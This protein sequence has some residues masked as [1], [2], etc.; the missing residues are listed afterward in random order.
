[1]KTKW[2]LRLILSGACLTDSKLVSFNTKTYGE[3]VSMWAGYV[4][5]AW[6][7]LVF[8]LGPSLDFFPFSWVAVDSTILCSQRWILVDLNAPT[9]AF[10]EIWGNHPYLFY[11][12]TDTTLKT[13]AWGCWLHL[14]ISFSRYR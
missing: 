2:P 8:A 5:S 3:H 12:L 6:C 1:M 9:V 14:L 11:I 10:I 7:E 4:S 13:L